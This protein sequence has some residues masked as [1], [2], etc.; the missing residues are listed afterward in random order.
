MNNT[1]YINMEHVYTKFQPENKMYEEDKEAIL[2][3]N[4]INSL[5]LT[6]PDEFIDSTHRVILPG[7]YLDV[8]LRGE[9]A[10]I[11]ERIKSG[12]GTNAEILIPLSCV[13]T[14]YGEDGHD[15]MDIVGA[16]FSKKDPHD[17]S[18]VS[19]LRYHKVN[20]KIYDSLDKVICK[21][22]LNNSG[23]TQI[24]LRIFDNKE[25]VLEYIQKEE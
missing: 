4:K 1:F 3:E 5:G 10:D 25:E 6:R 21:E 11:I 8:C 18:I 16:Y 24:E 2:L 12:E 20:Y 19:E 22:T 23:T 17:F 15:E 14:S 13:E 9:I 7:R